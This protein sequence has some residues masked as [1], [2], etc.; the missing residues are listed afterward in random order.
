METDKNP[1]TWLTHHHFLEWIIGFHYEKLTLPSAKQIV[2]P[3]GE[4]PEKVLVNLSCH[5]ANADLWII[6]ALT[7]P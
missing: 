2:K 5:H 4:T 1:K 6:S 7:Q 3:W